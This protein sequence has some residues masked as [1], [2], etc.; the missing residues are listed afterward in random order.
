VL[1]DTDFLPFAANADLPMAMTAHV[2]YTALDEERPATLSKRVI[3]YIRNDI[4]FAGMLLSDDLSMQALRGDLRGR[5]EAAF[6]AG[7]DL[8]LHCN[9][10]LAEAAAVAEAAPVLGGASLA[11]ASH[12]REWRGEAIA[13][14]PVEAWA[15]IEAALAI[16]A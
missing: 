14:D 5:A 4:G 8:A 6:A 1:R 3:D 15:E 9:G 10:D 16:A 11:R 7:I 2:V 12:A 13:F